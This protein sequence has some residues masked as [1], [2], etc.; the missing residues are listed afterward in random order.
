MIDQ[1]HPSLDQLVDYAH[2]E[3]PT[4]D[5]AAVY[6]HLAG[7]VPCKEAYDAESRLGELLRDHARAHERDLPL[8][9]ANAIYARA[10]AEHNSSRQWP[11]E[12]IGTSVRAAIAIPVAA[13]VALAIYFSANG[14]HGV[15]S[16]AVDARYYI[17]NHAALAS[18]TPFQDSA[19]PTMLTSEESQSQ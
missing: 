2:G 19:I 7:C 1:E 11:W 9:L 18:T 17:D 12:R 6:A 10:A 14:W 13:A 4:R 8:G 5:D 16:D 3:L 15:K